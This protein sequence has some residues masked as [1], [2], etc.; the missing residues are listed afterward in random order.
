M[1]TKETAAVPTREATKRFLVDCDSCS[2]ERTADGREEATR[3]GAD[4]RRATGHELV[5]LEVP[6][7]V[8]TA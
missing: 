1:A 5:A 8:E 6:Q 4:H 7:S 3:I 2:Y